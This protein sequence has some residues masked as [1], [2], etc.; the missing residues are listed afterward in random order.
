MVVLDDDD[1]PLGVLVDDEL[2]PLVPVPVVPVDPVPEVEPG[3]ELAL[4]DVV[5]GVLPVPV[6][7][8]DDVSGAVPEGVVL[9]EDD[10]DTGGGAGGVT[11]VVVDVDV[12]GV[13]DVVAGGVSCFWQAASASRTLAATAVRIG[14]FI[15]A[16]GW[17]RVGVRARGAACSSGYSTAPTT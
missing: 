14:R 17:E 4:L 9:D 3:V 5:P 8:L 1:P 7:L 16:P 13:V 12:G 2:V 11:T 6:V 10:D 15:V